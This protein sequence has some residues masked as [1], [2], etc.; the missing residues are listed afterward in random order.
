[1]R[2]RLRPDRQR[3]I[4][5]DQN[6]RVRFPRVRD[7]R[8]RW[9][10]GGWRVGGRGLCAGSATGHAPAPG[11][12]SGGSRSG[13]RVSFASGIG[14]HGST[15]AWGVPTSVP[16]S[17]PGS[18][19]FRDFFGGRVRGVPWR[20][21]LSR[22][23][24]HGTIS[25]LQP[26]PGR[27]T[28]CPPVESRPGGQHRPSRGRPVLVPGTSRVATSAA[29]SVIV[30]LASRQS[31]DPGPSQTTLSELSSRPKSPNPRS[32]HLQVPPRGEPGG[33]RDA[34]ESWLYR[35]QK[36]PR[37]SGLMPRSR[38]T[39]TRSGTRTGTR[40]GTQEGGGARIRGSWLCGRS[41]TGGEGLA[42]RSRVDVCGRWARWVDGWL[43]PGRLAG[44]P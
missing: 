41:G 6:H 5:R 23:R 20:V 25:E 2:F 17:G 37:S 14:G 38:R 43:S 28:R 31:R 34:T 10:R 44:C 18:Q 39:G 40:S 16:T 11:V 27:M 33:G 1:M 8:R 29:T 42:C 26:S 15:I 32:T 7:H 24:D 21:V 12:S 4:H 35:F 36:R 13:A 22:D 19:V 3:Q 9:C 30:D